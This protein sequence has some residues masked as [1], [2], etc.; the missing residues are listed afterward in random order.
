ME[1]QQFVVIEVDIYSGFVFI[2]LSAPAI[3]TIFYGLCIY[4]IHHHL[5]R[6]IYHIGIYIQYSCLENPKD[7]GAWWASIYGVAKSHTRLSD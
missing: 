4:Y 2:V 7:G 1:M 3:T 6:L 5:Q